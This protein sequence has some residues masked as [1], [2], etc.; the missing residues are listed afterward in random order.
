MP[1]ISKLSVLLTASAAGF[2]SGMAG[3]SKSLGKFHSDFSDVAGKIGALGAVIGAGAAV[4]GFASLVKSSFE[5]IDAL[6]DT[7]TA[8]GVTTEAL[9]RLQYAAK[10]AGLDAQGL[11][12]GLKFLEKNMSDAASG[13]TETGA[14]FA[15]LGL[16]AKELINIQPDQAFLK[17]AESISKVENPSQRTA[18]AMKVLGKEGAALLPLLSDGAE[19]IKKMFDESDKT[20]NTIKGIDAQNIAKANDSIDRMRLL[21]QGA[22]NT[23]AIQL[24]PFIQIAA[25]KLFELGQ[26]GGGAV[27]WIIKGF[28]MMAQAV[29][30]V[31]DFLELFESAWYV[32]KTIVLGAAFGIVKSI[33][34]VG[35]GLVKLMNLLP[36]VNVQWTDTF[37][38]MSDSLKKD[39]G[40]A[41]DE[42]SKHADNFANGKN[43]KAVT[44]FFD[45]VRAKAAQASGDAKPIGPPVDLAK[46]QKAADDLKKVTEQLDNLKKKFDELG[47][48]DG[49]KSIDEL[50]K[51]GATPEQIAQAQKLATAMDQVNK[52]GNIEL[53]NPID[54]YS[55]KMI[56]LNELLQ[57]GIINQD[58]FNNLANE[59]KESEVDA[60]KHEAVSVLDS[61]KS[62]VEKYQDEI[63][64]LQ[65]LR[66]KG[67]ID[68]DTFDK[69]SKKAASEID[70]GKS[71]Q[72]T[73][74]GSQAAAGIFAETQRRLQGAPSIDIPK[75]QLAEEKKHTQLLMKLVD[76][77][78]DSPEIAV[79][80]F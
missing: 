42:A 19:G 34:F 23:L 80:S 29:A 57:Q 41:F 55:G 9:S 49:Q 24:A 47:E 32:L 72:L 77:K 67:L 5:S 56:K 16:D 26:T 13:G 4:Y 71:P 18:L 33:D 21:I 45:D 35:G 7:A 75:N 11:N 15:A 3:A 61:I 36:G 64:K 48:T 78:T 2:T 76:V 73:A 51:L 79:V 68:D 59:A 60:L 22:A 31:S 53:G 8:L 65:T 63:R 30:Y 46:Y 70:K 40:D 10:F 74:V 14:A 69:A 58:Q 43:Q 52:L 54:T 62:P 44:Q 50:A 38:S 28:Q 66:A 12:T 20:G 39:M 17:I 27:S 1:V 6:N 25:D 37:A